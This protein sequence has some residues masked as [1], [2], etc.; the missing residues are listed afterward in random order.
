MGGGLLLAAAVG[1]L[2]AFGWLL[3]GSLGF[4]SAIARGLAAYVLAW[5]GLVAATVVLSVP[6]WLDRWSLAVAVAVLALVAALVRLRR[7]GRPAAPL[8]PAAREALAD[9]VVSALALA[10][11]VAGLYLGALAL[12]TTPNDWD[13]L[14][15]HET[16]ALLWDQ[17]GRV[18]YVPSGNDPRLDGNPPV[19]EIGL[20]LTMLLPRSERFAALPQYLALWAGLAAVLLVARGIGLS[21]R[22]AA[23]GGL[24][25]A[26]LPVVLLHG[27]AVLND[28]LV[29]SF[30]LAAVVFLLGRSRAELAL[31]SV[32]LGL[33]LSTKFNAVLAL[34][35]LLAVVLVG[36]PRDRRRP[37]LLALGAGV[38]LGAPW[39]VLNLV[40]TGSL[41]GDLG[42]TT[43]QSADHS[44]AGVLGTLRALTF[45]V[46]DTSGLWRSEILVAVGV[47]AVLAAAGAFR[48]FRDPRGRA[49]F[50]GGAVVALTPLFLRSLEGP[51][52]WLW[53]HSWFKLGREDIALDHGDAWK[54]MTLA[55]TS[56]SWY[57]ATGAVVIVGA[58]AAAVVG[59]RRHVLRPVAL[60]LALAPLVL[61][62]TFALT[63]VY[64]PWRGRLLMF[65]V[66]L[67]CAVWGWTIRVRWLSVGVAALCIT[68]L[69]L[70]LV[71]SYTKPSGFGLLEPSISRSVWHRDRIDTLTVIRNYDATPA[72]LRAVE[73]NVPSDAVIAAATPLDTFLAPLAGPHL[74]R[75][76]RLV[77][78]GRR[79]PSDAT[80]LV[81]RPT[82]VALA[83]PGTWETVF[84]EDSYHWRLL[85]RV[86]PDTCGDAVAPL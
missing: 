51:V 36:V 27:A 41:D 16:R 54:V 68:T 15:Y 33:A 56:L 44:F 67:A 52:R 60:A 3:A 13:G 78:D 18:G 42:E 63:I 37:S 26:T 5:A 61:V 82:P 70:S 53:E 73:E 75:T 28:L 24:V 20:Y 66:G 80:W 9:P 43:G 77:E 71:H 64:D 21:R 10:L 11:C 4:A 29:A 14:T 25:F 57:G 22:A 86:R 79:V 32:A 69:G 59:V 76:L 7:G 17:Q 34:P 48:G 40:E 30:L 45:D 39:Y 46:V 62:V 72:L 49:L 84:S 2:A 23:Y 47:G 74:S 12:F 85:R 38:L 58:V 35:V 81:A 83:C 1:C 6:G 19:S 65:G 31:G 50:V 8:G 55:D